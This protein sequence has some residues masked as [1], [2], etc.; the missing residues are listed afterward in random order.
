MTF[1]RS[2]KIFIYVLSIL[3]LS[4]CGS[5]NKQKETISIQAELDQ[6]TIYTYDATFGS[7]PIVLTQPNHGSLAITS[8][9]LTYT[10]DANYSGTDYA[11]IEGQDA[12]YNIHFTIHAVNQ[13]PFIESTTINVVADRV[14]AGHVVVV[15]P[16]NDPVTF[17]LLTSPERGTFEF[18]TETGEFTYT[19]AGL[20]LPNASF[21]ISFND[22]INPAQQET[23]TL[24]PAYESNEE[25]SAYYYHS[26]SSH[27]LQAELRLAELG[28]DLDI[29]D[30]LVGI[31][32]GYVLGN[33]PNEV[34]RILLE[35]STEQNQANAFRNVAKTLSA[36]GD[37]QTAREY[38]QR[39]L[40]IYTGYVVSNGI[41]NLSGA[42]S[43][44]FL[45]LLNNADAAGDLETAEKV[46]QQMEV[47]IDVLDT[48]IYD[49]P[50]G[51]LTTAYRNQAKGAIDKYTET[52]IESDRLKA[53]AAVQRFASVVERTGVQTVSRGANKGKL[54]YK[55]A[56]LYNATAA[57]YFQ[58]LGEQGL[59]RRSLAYTLS[60]Y[61]TAD[62]DAEYTF[63]VKPHADIT[64][65]EYPFPLAS[66]SKLFDLLYP[67][68]ETNLAFVLIP[69]DNFAYGRAVDGR[70]EAEPV[71]ML[72]NGSPVAAAVEN[73]E[74]AYI[75]DIKKRMTAFADVSETLY[76]LG[77]TQAAQAFLT[78]A[79]NI[80]SSEDYYLANQNS[81]LY[82]TGNRGCNKLIKQSMNQEGVTSAYSTITQCREDYIDSGRQSD[83]LTA[84]YDAANW[85]LYGAQVAAEGPELNL[86]AEAA[87]ILR[88]HT[89][90]LAT[91]D[92]DEKAIAYSAFAVLAANAR[93]YHEINGY[94][95]AAFEAAQHSLEAV[96]TGGEVERFTKL[97]TVLA[98]VDGNT[99]TDT[100]MAHANSL[101]NELRSHAYNEP[102]YQDLLRSIQQKSATLLSTWVELAKGLNAVEQVDAA[103]VIV[104]LFAQ[105]R[106]YGQAEN[107]L[108]ELA[109][110]KA[111]NI[112]LFADISAIQAV[113]DDFPASRVASVDTDQDGRANFY[114]IN[115]TQQ[116]RAETDIQL[117]DDADG[118]GVL[119]ELDPCPLGCE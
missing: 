37:E 26:Q 58:L 38:R 108:Q 1:S 73:L 36:V 80:L 44:F 63:P 7:T 95:D 47:F 43:G 33:L 53:V 88:N 115:S 60:Y 39:A 114:A 99:A 32:Q 61:R 90:V 9:Q 85:Y 69:E 78:Q 64:V 111:D 11:E 30:A 21:S 27:L 14:V 100:G 34:E 17:E 102:V 24:L 107:I 8:S 10:P 45:T 109:P 12:L 104:P 116:E 87:A 51:R 20:R 105:V 70:K 110:N 72:A 25:K 71:V 28:S 54:N 19:Q 46:A 82:T 86:L 16:E 4:A 79:K 93:A 98:R 49:T 91:L 62:Y 52:G 56:P 76:A 65:Q 75:D 103:E 6:N 13:A 66:A 57:E 18:N 97:S 31:A 101:L 2:Q 94:L 41:E 96:T 112:S 67:T 42:D 22:G 83:Q 59:A 113:Q 74:T 5:S 89:Q 35:F 119:D 3:I 68:A 117:D 50:F 15:D 81:T 118:D 84:I 92:N 55:L 23:I 48:G 106:L 40:E 77:E 29:S